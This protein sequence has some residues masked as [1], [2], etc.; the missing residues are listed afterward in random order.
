MLPLLPEAELRA[1]QSDKEPVTHTPVYSKL[2]LTALVLLEKP[3]LI[4]IPRSSSVQNVHLLQYGH[5]RKHDKWLD[6]GAM[7][8]LQGLT[9]C[10]FWRL[11]CDRDQRYFNRELLELAEMIAKT[12][13]FLARFSRGRHCEQLQRSARIPV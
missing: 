13:I 1:V 2:M 5:D 6:I 11:D 3:T 4:E 7:G 9:W 10:C 12:C 8:G